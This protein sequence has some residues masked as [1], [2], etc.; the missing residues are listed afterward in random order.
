MRIPHLRWWIAGALMTASVLNYLDRS[1]LGV[2]SAHIIDDFHLS[3]S[4]YA[5]IVNAF[6][7]AYTLSYAVGGVLGDRLG[8]RGTIGVTLAWWS[9]AN[10]LH[11]AASG[12]RSLMAFRFLLGLGEAAYYPAALRAIAEWFPPRERS[13]PVGLLLAGASLGAVLAP[14]IVGHMMALP[15]IGWRGAFAF[16]GALGF[17]VLPFWLL[18]YRTP[19][20]HSHRP[21]T[22]HGSLE[23]DPDADPSAAKDDGAPEPVSHGKAPQPWRVREILSQPQAWSL[24]LARLLTDGGWF[25]LL[26]WI[27]LYL[28]KGR[29]FSDA[30]IRN[31]AWI[32]YAAADLGALTG[33]W[34]CSALIRGKA[35][36]IPTRKRCM[37]AF[38]CLLPAS[39][40]GYLMPAGADTAA[41]A[42]LSLACFG[43]MAWGSNFL[44]LHSDV[45]PRHTVASIMG[46][47]GAAGSIGGILA[48]QT[49]GILVDRTGTYLRV[50]IATS[51]L[52]PL[53][54]MFLWR[55]LHREAERKLEKG[56]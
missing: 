15:G 52:H 45:F 5:L 3:K 31:Y 19:P 24:M 36:V 12:L 43:H 44:T 18:L 20:R 16:T 55:T 42:F 47:S 7:L 53:A 37:V 27:S 40:I 29:G 22:G 32:P 21:S 14:L 30:Q 39:L 25:L 51:C 17:L 28:Q 1:A 9:A 8:A 6:L 4:Q 38:A 56:Y 48:G 11:A 41:V 2:A 26:F 10:M 49:V 35:A 34:L 33:G 46:L 54:A 23:A 13:K 50:F